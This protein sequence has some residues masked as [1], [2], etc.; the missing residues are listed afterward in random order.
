MTNTI[1]FLGESG[2]YSDLACQNAMPDYKT[3]PC[4]SFEDIIQSVHDGKAM[5]AILPVENSI[6]GRVA[7]VHELLPNSGLT[8]VGEHYQPIIHHL[9]GMK[10]ATIDD[11]KT[12]QSHEQPLSQCKKW[13]RERK[14]ETIKKASTTI[15]A[16][17]LSKEIKD[18][19]VGVIASS[20]AGDIYGLKSLAKDIA[21]IKNNTTRFLILSKTPA[22]PDFNTTKCISSI[23][24][25]VRSVP[26]ALYKAMGGFA[27]NGVNITKIESYLID[28]KFNA[29]QFYIDVEGHPDQTALKNALEELDFFADYLK[30]MGT[31]PASPF[32]DQI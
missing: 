7:D 24:F 2:S 4:S 20:V 12:V 25:R 18:K 21:D 6:A 22:I 3:L 31:Y 16:H 11:I 14:I 28:G 13:L 17:Q 26:A 10:D 15:A 30:I 1:A 27:T 9:L 29:A 8:I 23:M 32:R 19:T 5:L